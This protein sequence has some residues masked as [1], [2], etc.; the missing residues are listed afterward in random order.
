MSQPTPDLR[1]LES[2]LRDCVKADEA[3]HGKSD[4]PPDSLWD[5]LQ[6]VAHIAEQL[7][8]EEG[9]DPVACR[10][11]GL[12][13]DAGKF[14]GGTYHDGD[15]PEEERAVQVLRDVASNAAVDA[16]L[17]DSVAEAIVQIYRDDPDLTDLAKVLFDADNLDKLGPQGVANYFIKTGLRGAGLSRRTLFQMTVE[18][19]Y[20][21]HAERC[22]L[23]NAGRA[24]AAKRAPE[25]REML[26]RVIETLRE[27]GLFDFDVTEMTVSGLTLDVVSPTKCECGGEA[28]IEVWEVPGIKCSEVHLSHSCAAC[29]ARRE[30]RF[31]RPRLVT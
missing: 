3:A 26:L 23:T 24:R 29:G 30:I 6:R 10:L 14:A 9:V 2:T 1:P 20:A 28:K 4:R 8:R 11:A 22:L 5:H 7:G 31:C 17:I 16:A 13:H 19:T 18:L 21:R 27:D 15:V 12:F 25:T